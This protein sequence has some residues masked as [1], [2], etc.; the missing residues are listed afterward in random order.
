MTDQSSIS[1]TDQRI[2]D[3]RYGGRSD[4][5][6]KDYVR[7]VKKYHKELRKRIKEIGGNHEIQIRMQSFYKGEE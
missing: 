2:F 1:A 6:K 3:V 7:F 5:R 4:W